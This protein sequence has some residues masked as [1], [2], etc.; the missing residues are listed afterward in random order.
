MSS[1]AV[2]RI[3]REFR[4]VAADIASVSQY[5]IQPNEQDLLSLQGYVTGPPDTPYQGGKFFLDVKIPDTYPFSPP[6]VSLEPRR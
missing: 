6:R 2:Q 5:Y 1:I 4:E 3:Q